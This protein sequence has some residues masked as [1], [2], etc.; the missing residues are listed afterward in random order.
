MLFILLGPTTISELLFEENTSYYMLKCNESTEGSSDT[1]D[2]KADKV[3]KIVNTL[4]DCT[5]VDL[6]LDRNEIA[7]LLVSSKTIYLESVSRPPE[8]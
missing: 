5:L 2:V 4:D 8:G 1:E 6:C 7:F 3:K